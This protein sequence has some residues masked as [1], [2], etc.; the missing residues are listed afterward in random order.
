MSEEIRAKSPRTSGR[1]MFWVGLLMVIGTAVYW[2][3][4]SR[5]FHTYRL[6]LITAGVDPYWNLVMD[7]ARAA[8]KEEGVELTI[9]QPK[10]LEDQSNKI[11]ATINGGVDGL[12]I[13]PVSAIRELGD[14]DRAGAV[15]KLVTL[16]TD[17]PLANRVCFVGSDNYEAGR[18]A[19]DLVK[20]S[21]PDGGAIMVCLDSLDKDSAQRRRQ[22]LI[23]ALLGRPDEPTRPAD[24]V[25]GELKG[26]K[27]NVTATLVDNFS[28]ATA[29]DLVVKAIKDHPEVKCFVGLL[30]NTTPALLAGLQQAGKLDQ[31]R[32]V[33]FDC[34]ART[35][36]GIRENHVFG[37]IRQHQ[38]ECGYESVRILSEAVK[39]NGGTAVPTYPVVNLSTDII[40]KQTLDAAAT[41]PAS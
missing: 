19:A 37:T 23:D 28:P 38:Y 4:Q 6:T 25:D 41:Q 13:S 17:C 29:S 8:A 18:S 34:D 27:Y 1:W 14:L 5:M 20:Q 16:D 32:L 39:G 36:A 11:R 3:Q 26:P 35:L 9:I 31:I 24:P 21:L 10:S 33:G 40:T 7:G 15:S 30:A 22:G 2:V 12:A